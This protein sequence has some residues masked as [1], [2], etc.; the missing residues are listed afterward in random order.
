METLMNTS[1][2][3]SVF[4]IEIQDIK[5]VGYFMIGAHPS[6]FSVYPGT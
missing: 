2:V 6:L 4:W 5:A 1:W 3:T